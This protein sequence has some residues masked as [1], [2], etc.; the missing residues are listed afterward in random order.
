M[1]QSRAKNIRKKIGLGR[2]RKTIVVGVV[3][4][5]IIAYVFYNSYA[6]FLIFPIVYLIVRN[7][8]K[9]EAKQK[10]KL[11]LK[12]MFRDMM[13]S[14]A[15][16]LQAGYAVEKAMEPVNEELIIL[17]SKNSPI[18]NECEKIIQKIGANYPI[19]KAFSES[20]KSMQ[21]EEASAFAETF[22]IG[23][24]I[25]GDMNRILMDIVTVISEKIDTER[26]IESSLA[27]KR[28]EFRIMCIMP[29]A[30]IS[31]VRISS[32]GYFQILYHN[33][34]G[35]ILMTFVLGMILCTYMLAK[36]IIN[37]EV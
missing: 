32:P 36:K 24:H 11:E 31:Y 5:V 23:K 37:I 13:L 27:A 26:E 2:E 33:L 14:L 15:A 9:E 25:G 34:F 1:E 30:M 28:F 3:L 29:F 17:Y 16:A 12:V 10:G 18:V 19:E 7:V 20:A 6:G 35:V 8:I 21:L 22:K 4:T